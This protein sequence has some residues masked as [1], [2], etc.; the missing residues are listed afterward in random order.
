MRHETSIK[1]SESVNITLIRIPYGSFVMGSTQEDPDARPNE[2]PAHE[3]NVES[4][5]FGKFPVT[6][7]QWN[8]VFPGTPREG[9][10]L[11]PAVNVHL[12]QAVGFCERISEI[13]EFKVRLPTETEWEYACRAGT[14][15]RYSFGDEIDSD[16]VNH[17]QTDGPWNVGSGPSNDFGLHD[18]HGCVWEWCADDWH[19]NYVGAPNDGSAWLGGGDGSYRVQRGG[20]WDSRARRCRSAYRVGDIAQN[21]ADIVGLRIAADNFD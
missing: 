21:N 7:A 15:T 20:A 17:D 13:S 10:D 12:N 18:M 16:L 9:R 19:T 14:T 2:M 6:N 8:A 4:F 5:W 11:A 1:L 3:V